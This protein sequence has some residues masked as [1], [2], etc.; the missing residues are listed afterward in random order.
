MT[1]NV[2]QLNPAATT[3]DLHS[4]VSERFDCARRLL[5]SLSCLPPSKLDVEDV[6][7]IAFGAR[8]MLED[9]CEGLKRLQL[10][11]LNQ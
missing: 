8:L 6:L 2:I 1:R 3:E 7:T 9:G 10:T 11:V 5:D 4:F